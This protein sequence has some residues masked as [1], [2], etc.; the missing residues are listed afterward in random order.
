VTA[1][2][3]PDRRRALLWILAAVLALWVVS[4]VHTLEAPREFGVV[5]LRGFGY[6]VTV[7][8]SGFALAPP[9]AFRVT[10][11][12]RAAIECDLPGAAHARLASDDGSLFGLLGTATLRADPA[13]GRELAAAAG[14]E[15]IDGVLLAAV[16]AAAPALSGADPAEHAVPTMVRAFESRLESELEARGARLE[17]LTL[18]GFEALPSR[19]D[20]APVPQEA[21]V[22][23]V[24]LDGADWE[25]IDPLLAA[26]RLPH[27]ERLI[28]EGA[29]SKLLTIT[30]VLSPVVWTSIATGVEPFRHGILDFLTVDAQGKSEPVS[31]R[32]R[33]VPTV[34]EML[35]G[36][37]VPVG[38][39]AWWATWPA[40]PVKGYLVT[41]RVAYQLFGY[42]S[43]ARSSEGKTWPPELY[44]RAVRPHIV[45]PEAVPWSEVTPYLDGE[46]RRLEQFDAEERKLLEDFRTLLASGRTYLDVGLALRRDPSVRFEAV[47]FEGTDTV[48][49]LFMPYRAPRL[50]SV[51]E[52]RF[53]SFHAMVDR[54][55]ETV[56]GMLGKLLEG[57]QGWTVFIVSDH[58]FSSDATRPLT[59]DSRIGHGAAADWH[60]RF[61][62]LVMS[63]PGVRRGVRLD[64][65]SIYDVAPT[66]L[67]LFGQPVP[68]SWPGRVL[69]PALDRAFL[70][71]HPV[72]F[73]ASDPTRASPAPGSAENGEEAEELRAKLESLGYLAPARAKRPMTTSNN[74]GVALLAEGKFEAAADAFR[75]AIREEPG[76]STLWV[77][78][79]I[80]LRHAGKDAEA[81][82]LF[83]RA[84]SR[85]ESRR[86]AGHQLAQLLME[87]GDLPGAESVL[88]GVLADEPG[89][90]EVRNALGLVLDQAG[91]SKEA[92]KEFAASAELDP[93]AAEPRNNLGNLAKGAGRRE[94]AARWYE[95]AIAADPYF[96]G[97]YNNLA[98]LHQERGDVTRAIELY[99]RALAKAP[100]NAVVLNNLASLYFSMADYRE[101]A[102][103]WQRSIDADPAYASPVNNLAGLALAQGDLD[104]AQLLLDRAL[105]LDPHY[106]DARINRAI[107]A[108]R[109]GDVVGARA[110]LA[111][112]LED[113]RAVG[114]AWLQTGFLELEAGRPAVASEAL[115]RARSRLGDRTDLLN[116]LGESYA[117]MGEGSR[118]RAAWERSLALDPQQ[119]RLKE[120]LEK[121]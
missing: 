57:R 59:T 89:A 44:D 82:E 46:R 23:V 17:R 107:L 101:A 33:L 106:G 75:D 42:R 63:G 16:K 113:P 11:F 1:R 90:A 73:R 50:P 58:G 60:R 66:I 8:R 39:T 117:R 54:Y 14:G 77:N 112:A 41:D 79:G 85:P 104:Q 94:E 3:G 121:L 18:S 105:T 15:G 10:E 37:G 114:M 98:L 55:Y 4:G 72:T 24:G 31:S 86:A 100:A 49:H 62:I 108:R 47:Y 102:S 2:G 67:A 25:I 81:G 65:A 109:R 26:G 118:A 27:L 12:P 32:E 93:N 36:A 35:S 34:W 76:Q 43:D 13:H 78:L 69:G 115:Q 84:L 74:R 20:V 51:S 52:A 95:A 64:E 29:R 111:R 80:A 53:R 110:E 103:L 88:R 71:R 6:L 9:G 56:D 120:A 38:V 61:G 19:A 92:W 70:S 48:G 5:E 40:S 30:P 21:R 22:L 68:R 96:M 99:G 83:R 91:R 28:R 97:A 45:G 116:A 7:D 87:E 119:L